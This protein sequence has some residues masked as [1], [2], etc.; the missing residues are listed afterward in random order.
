MKE[1]H[2][3]E[4]VRILYSA[5]LRGD[6]SGVLDQMDESI[7]LL[8]PGSP[9]VPTAGIRRGIREVERFFE[10]LRALIEYTA[11]ET[12]EFI[13]QGNRVVALLHYEG[14]NRRTGKSF[15]VDSAV[16][17]TLGNGKAIRG[18]EFT[19][20]EALAKAAEAAQHSFGAA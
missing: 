12:R 4:A 11:F 15:A 10:D 9:A 16:L 3:I 18:Q 19:D 20:T 6:I 7:T 17:W 8:L 1:S 14:R 5:F 13:A 2:N